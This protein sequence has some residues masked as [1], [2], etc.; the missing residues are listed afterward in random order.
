MD[1]AEHYRRLSN[2][3]K[4]IGNMRLYVKYRKAMLNEQARTYKPRAER[5]F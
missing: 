3:A 1:M 5:Q 4:K 2:E